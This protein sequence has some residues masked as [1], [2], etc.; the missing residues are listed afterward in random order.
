MRRL[1]SPKEAAPGL[2]WTPALDIV[3]GVLLFFVLCIPWSRDTVFDLS[4]PVPSRGSVRVLDCRGSTVRV[5]I[6]P[7]DRIAVDGEAIALADLGDRL[8]RGL[9]ADPKMSVVVRV[10]GQARNGRLVELIDALHL[11]GIR[12]MS[13]AM[14]MI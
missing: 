6:D 12:R 3:F 14:E 11:A 8:R 10:A 7:D 2:D 13:L 4:P 9:A 1:R 5:V